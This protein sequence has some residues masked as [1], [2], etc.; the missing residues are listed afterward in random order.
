MRQGGISNA[1]TLAKK[2][3]D[4]RI[5]QRLG[6]MQELLA[7]PLGEDIAQARRFSNVFE[8]KA[9]HVFHSSITHD[10][11]GYGVRSE[12]LIAALQDIG[13]CCAA[14]TRLGYPWDL[15][16][17]AKLS[18]QSTQSSSSTI[19]YLHSR[20]NTWTL[21]DCESGYLRAYAEQIEIA[22]ST[23]Q[24]S[25]I[26]AHSN[27]L[28]G[29]AAQ[30]AG[31]R[32]SVPVVYEMRGLW[33]E[34]RALTNP[35]YATTEHY[36]YCEKQE[37][38]AAMLADAVVAI[39][40]PLADWLAIKGVNRSK[41]T[42]IGN[43]AVERRPVEKQASPEFVIGYVGSLVEYEGI[44]VL[45]AAFTELHKLHDQVRLVIV[46]D[47][48]QRKTI[49]N[50]VRAHDLAGRVTLPGRV[51][52]GQ[53]EDYYARFDVAVVPR[54]SNKVTELVPPL[55]PMEIMAMGVPLVVSNVAPLS[56]LVTHESN[57]LVFAAG[58]VADLMRCIQKLVHQPDL[59]AKLRAAGLVSASNNS[60]AR[61]A[62]RY[63]TLYKQ[64]GREGSSDQI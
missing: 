63:L 4:T 10:T 44:D 3:G 23:A 13:I 27:Y 51:P 32:L 62:Q 46:G 30:I 25:V 33:H 39:S 64:F 35:S 54:N 58:D 6:E 16:Q 40:K 60:W 18:E 7:A 5:I 37:L 29:L 9:L 28:N 12:Q 22:A 45:L 50:W 1:Y 19:R 59:G 49:E 15:R 57:A 20:S 38:R 41:I 11:N 47:G 17:H 43:A 61:N 42:T 53:V 14:M 56:E 34:T 21:G 24:A 31:Q 48:A 2:S 55:K 26:H 8:P 52:P 36:R